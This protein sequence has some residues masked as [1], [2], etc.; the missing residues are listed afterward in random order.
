[1][2]PPSNVEYLT[3]H[4]V[5]RTLEILTRELLSQKPDNPVEVIVKLLKEMRIQEKTKR[6]E[7]FIGG[8]GISEVEKNEVDRQ[9]GAIVSLERDESIKSESSTFSINNTDMSE[10]ISDVRVAYQ[11]LSRSRVLNGRVTRTD[12]GD[13][14]D[15]IAYP[16]PEKILCE[17][18]AEVD[19]ENSGDV[20]FLECLTRMTFKIQGRYHV[21]TLRPI[22]QTTISE[23]IHSES[24]PL[25]LLSTA[26]H[27]LG[28]RSSPD[29]ITSALSQLGRGLSSEEPISLKIFTSIVYHLTGHSEYI[30]D[31]DDDITSTGIGQEQSFM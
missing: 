25:S 7:N 26:L 1:M 13:I 19:M 22:F 15:L 5:A 16:I 2:I 14:I 20:D 6:L 8:E 29:D 30:D 11:Q 9:M 3:Q 18:F 17:M 27:R 4:D 10:F 31:E 23:D 28:L 24:L 12:L 21:D